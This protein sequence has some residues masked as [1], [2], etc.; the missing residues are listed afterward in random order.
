MKQ[1]LKSAAYVAILFGISPQRVRALAHS[2]NLG[3]KAGNK[4][5]LFSPAEIETMRDRKPGRPKS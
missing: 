2:R 5:W 4:M 1:E 3:W